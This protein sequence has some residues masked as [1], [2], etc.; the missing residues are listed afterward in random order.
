MTRI[1]RHKND[2]QLGGAS[3]PPSGQ[4]GFTLT[5][6]LISLVVLSIGLLGLSALQM[7]ALRNN[8]SAYYRSVATQQ[9]YDMADRI[10]ANSTSASSYNNPTATQDAACVSATGCSGSAMAGHDAYEW[11]QVNSSS[12]PGGTGVVCIDSTPDDG[13]PAAPACDGNGN[14]FAI[15]IWWDDDRSGATDAADPRFGMSFV[16]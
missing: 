13:T 10:R 12:L 2:G 3:R 14:T 16:P 1:A 7:T 15:K 5:E 6:I 9:A 8:Q 4:S 11:N